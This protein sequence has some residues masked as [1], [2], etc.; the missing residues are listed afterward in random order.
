V[1]TF[2][3]TIKEHING[4]ITILLTEQAHVHALSLLYNNDYHEALERCKK[5]AQLLVDRYKTYFEGLDVQWWQ[6]FIRSD[7]EYE[8]FKNLIMETYKTDAQFQQLVRSDAESSY[9]STRAQEASDKELY[10]AKT[11]QDLL[12]Q[13]IYIFIVSKRGYRFDFYPGKPYSSSEYINNNF[14]SANKRLKRIVVCLSTYK[15]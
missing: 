10:I 7:S 11:I 1:Q 5:D 12:E 14:L 2:L 3:S 6:T 4:K 9:T 13:A 8:T 15:K